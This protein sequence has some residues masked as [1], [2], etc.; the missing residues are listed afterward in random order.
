[1]TTTEL[2]LHK[3]PI[4]SEA[5]LKTYAQK[6][7]ETFY[8]DYEL[9]DAQAMLWQIMVPAF[10]N[11]NPLQSNEEKQALVLFYERLHELLLAA[12]MLHNQRELNNCVGR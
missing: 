12:A 1:M 6:V 5:E 7:L 10:I 8:I 11:S 4:G 9:D 2:Y 3:R